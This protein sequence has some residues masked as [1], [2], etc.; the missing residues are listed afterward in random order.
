[1]K[2]PKIMAIQLRNTI[3]ALHNFNTDRFRPGQQYIQ[4][5]WKYVLVY[6]KLRSLYM[7]LAVEAVE[8]HGHGF[9]RRR[10]LIQQGSIGDRQSS[11]VANHGLKV[12]Q[13]L[14]TTLR[15]FS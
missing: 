12:Q 14:Q 13:T 10:T 8:K 4:R 2:C 6:K 3:I 9:R 7:I 5:L 15:Y 1:Y 11:K